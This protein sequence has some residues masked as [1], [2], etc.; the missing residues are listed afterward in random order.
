M[1]TTTELNTHTHKQTIPL[2][3]SRIVQ[4][5]FVNRIIG[6]IVQI[7]YEHYQLSEVL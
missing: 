2:R 5:N 6:R 3:E 4:W 7:K 1:L